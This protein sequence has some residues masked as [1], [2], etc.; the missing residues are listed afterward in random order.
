MNDKEV[1]VKYYELR[2]CRAVGEYYKCSGE[3]IRRI[4]ID[5]GIKLTGWKQTKEYRL[6]RK[7]YPDRHKYVPVSYKRVC[8]YCG[9]EYIAKN[10]RSMYCS[11]RCKD[12]A[13]KIKNGIKCNTNTEPYHKTCVVC[14]KPFDTY[15]KE[16]VTCSHECSEKHRSNYWK[17]ERTWDEYVKEIKEKAEKR[18]AEKRLAR[19]L[20][21]YANTKVEKECKYCGKTFTSQWPTAQFCSDECRRKWKNRLKDKRIKKESIIDTD[22]TLQ[23]LFNR[24]EGVCWICG[25][26]C[27]WNDKRLSANGYEYP[28]DT[29]PTKDHVIPIAQGGKESWDNVR[30]AHWKCNL[31]KSDK[32]Y[33]YVQMDKSFA[34]SYKKKG[35]P[36]KK[37]AQYTLDGQL[38][39]IWDSTAQIKREL[40]LNDK[41]I[42]NVCR[43][44][45]SKT[46]NAYGYHWEYVEGEKCRA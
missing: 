17:S 11:K 33:P 40:G 2:S 7:K 14:G 42:Q 44:D 26:K 4:L 20:R 29:Y 3:T 32:I 28:G 36:S 19:I 45:G 12:I 23:K 10:K 16:V 34:Y 1:I 39:K 35:N 30:L 27:D 15:R 9:K 43:R 13:I 25:E 22:I 46:G 38:I 31:E 41:H 6:P 8:A 21:A 18:K 5:N 24:D 37:T